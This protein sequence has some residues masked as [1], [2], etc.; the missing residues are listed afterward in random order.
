MMRRWGITYHGDFQCNLLLTIFASSFIPPNQG[1]GRGAS[2][3]VPIFIAFNHL[4]LSILFLFL[5][6][7]SDLSETSS[8]SYQ[9]VP[10]VR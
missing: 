8:F 6:Q 7:P 3:C 10:R 1:H 4:A 2:S 9:D 5:P